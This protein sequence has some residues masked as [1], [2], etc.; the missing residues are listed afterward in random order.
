MTSRQAFVY[1]LIPRE[2]AGE[3]KG[4]AH[5]HGRQTARFWPTEI[6]DT[7]GVARGR[8]CRADAACGLG[9]KPGVRGRAPLLLSAQPCPVVREELSLFALAYSVLSLAA[10]EARLRRCLRTTALAMSGQTEVMSHDRLS[11]RS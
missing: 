5:A 1:F 4:R 6:G 11:D 2:E 3:T 8:P 10:R 9:G 7:Q